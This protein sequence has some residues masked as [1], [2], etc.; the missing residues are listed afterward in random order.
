LNWFKH[1]SDAST[2]AK[3][4][5]L[6]IRYGA[7]GYAIYFHCLEL[8]VGD[9]NENNITFELEHDAEIIAD[10]LKIKGTADQSGVERVNE[11]M[12]YI[13]SLGLFQEQNGHIFCFKLLK[14]LD[15]SMTS[16]AN[17][18][19]MITEAKE[20]HDAVMISHDDIMQD[21]TRRE[22]IRL[23]EKEYKNVQKRFQ[24]PTIDQITEYCT[25]RSNSID[26]QQFF[27]YYEA[28]GWHVGRNPMKDWKSAVRYWERNNAGKS[29]GRKQPSKD[30]WD[31]PDYYKKGNVR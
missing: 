21:K 22:E 12:R 6:L 24:K 16:N 23:E 29:S 28:N 13:V 31:D 4:K 20:N 25:E 17:F 10:N 9:V 18:R 8:I 19:K 3:I 14:R 1:D 27:D 5:K 7:E 30:P 15:S 2:D 11:I 26:P